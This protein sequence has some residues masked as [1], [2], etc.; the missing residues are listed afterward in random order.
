MEKRFHS[1]EFKIMIVE[2]KQSGMSSKNIGEEYNLNPSMIS[3][4]CREYKAKSG[5]LLKAKE[6]SPQ[7][8]ELRLLR[9]ELKDVKLERDVLKKAVS[10]FSKNDR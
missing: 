8:K 9:K 6:L 1:N 2:L 3:R 5:D 4:W 10:I 7:E